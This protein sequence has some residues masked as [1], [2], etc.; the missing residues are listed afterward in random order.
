MKIRLVHLCEGKPKK[1]PDGTLV[2][3]DEIHLYLDI[4]MDFLPYGTI[5]LKTPNG[6]HCTINQDEPKYWSYDYNTT[7]KILKINVLGM[8]LL[9]S[10]NYEGVCTWEKDW[11]DSFPWEITQILIQKGWKVLNPQSPQSFKVL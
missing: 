4:E 3:G 6:I 9:L 10:T 11:K 1:D 2:E 7:S 5:Y 8:R